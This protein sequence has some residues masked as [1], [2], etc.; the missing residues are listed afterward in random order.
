M[1][2]WRGRGL[3]AIV[4]L[5]DGIIAVKGEQR[6]SDESVRV[7]YELQC[8]GFVTHIEKSQWIP[9]RSLEWL[10]F[11]VDLDKGEFSVPQNKLD[12]LKCQLQAISK[13]PGVPARQLASVIGRI[14]SMSLALGPVTRLMT[15]KLYFLLNQKTAWCQY[16]PLSLDAKQ[17][18]AF[19]LER[20]TE[21]NGQNIWPKPSA[22]RVVYTDAS[23]TGYGGYLVEHGNLVANGQWAND[24]EKQSSTWRELWAVRLVLESFQTLLKN[25]RVR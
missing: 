12:A 25:E 10:G 11:I 3:K 14:M 21:F 8:A 15:R 24:G 6:A 5:D 7:R 16:L 19:W 4:Y 2:H 1:R 9:S 22:M 13:V 18:L 20:I 23:D 17:E